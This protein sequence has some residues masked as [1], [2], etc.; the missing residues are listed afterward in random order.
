MLEQQRQQQVG[1]VQQQQQQQQQVGPAEQQVG[2]LAGWL[3]A[4][5]VIECV[6]PG[7]PTVLMKNDDASGGA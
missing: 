2:W 5:A 6:C 4:G 1:R 7:S 3:S